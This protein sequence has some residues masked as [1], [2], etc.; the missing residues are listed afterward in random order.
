MPGAL[1][2]S[3]SRRPG[4]KRSWSRTT[5]LPLASC[6]VTVRSLEPVPAPSWSCLMMSNVAGVLVALAL[7]AK[8]WAMDG[9]VVLKI[10]RELS[11]ALA[12]STAATSPKIVTPVEPAWLTSFDRSEPPTFAL[13]DPPSLAMSEPPSL[14]INEAPSL[15]MRL[16]PSFAMSEPPSLAMS[17]PPSLAMS[18]V[19]TPPFWAWTNMLNAAS[20]AVECVMSVCVGA[21]LGMDFRLK[22]RLVKNP[23]M[24]FSNPPPVFVAATR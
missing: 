1:Y 23:M 17:E 2:S 9:A 16:P 24:A 3:T 5:V 11:G 19:P 22:K 18:P 10:A 7:G 14:A 6:D 13:N 8:A 4:V 21:A 15:L 20:R 12:L